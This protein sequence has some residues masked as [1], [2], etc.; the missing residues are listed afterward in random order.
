MNNTDYVEKLFKSKA[1]AVN[2]PLLENE[3]KGCAKC[4]RLKTLDEVIEV[5]TRNSLFP[6]ILREEIERRRMEKDHSHF[7]ACKMISSA[8]ILN[9]NKFDKINMPVVF[10]MRSNSKGFCYH[11]STCSEYEP[12]N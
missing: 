1:F 8:F 4:D 5:M 3:K 12:E 10:P 11:Q 2:P 6:F 9:L 7:I